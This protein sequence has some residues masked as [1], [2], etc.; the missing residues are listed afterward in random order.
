MKIWLLADPQSDLPSLFDLLCNEELQIYN[1]S[2]EVLERLRNSS[3]SCDVLIVEAEPGA[4]LAILKTVK[5]HFP[6]IL[7]VLA[8]GQDSSTL[9]DAINEAQIFHHIAKPFSP[10]RVRLCLNSLV[11]ELDNRD[12]AAIA[13][14]DELMLWHEQLI[15]FRSNWLLE[16]IG[17][18][19]HLRERI[20][21]FIN[22]QVRHLQDSGYQLNLVDRILCEK[23]D[24]QQ[25]QLFVRLM[26]DLS[27]IDKRSLTDVVQR[28][29]ADG[30]IECKLKG[31]RSAIFASPTIPNLSFFHPL[32]QSVAKNHQLISQMVQLY[33]LADEVTLT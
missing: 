14:L 8:G 19:H 10:E 25:E 1:S 22:H 2:Q 30:R 17:E 23:S 32:A 29:N 33:L 24:R 16:V 13:E 11:D 31:S 18:N 3:S 12:Q 20:S 26:G 21:T 7:R 5:A 28:I 6:K 9:I 15:E 4:S 27:Q